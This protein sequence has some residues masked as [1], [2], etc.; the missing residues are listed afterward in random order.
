MGYQPSGHFLDQV[1]KHF[2]YED[3]VDSSWFNDVCHPFIGLLEELYAFQ[4]EIL[5]KLGAGAETGR[6]GQ[7]VSEVKQVI[8]YLQDLELYAI[9]HGKAGF[10]DGWM[11][12]KL[13]YQRLSSK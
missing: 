9:D 6:T 4:G 1:V 12:G 7:A 11:G 5:N 10:L 8:G 13:Y 2:C 3:G